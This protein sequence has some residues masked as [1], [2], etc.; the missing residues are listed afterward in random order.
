MFKKILALTL[1]A[2]ML[3]TAAM[4]EGWTAPAA[5]DPMSLEGDIGLYLNDTFFYIGNDMAE[6]KAVLGE[7]D[8]V[9]A[10]PSCAFKG[11]DKEY[12]YPDM[13]VMTM[14]LGELD[15]WTE[16]YIEGGDYITSRGIGIGATED[17]VLAAYGD[18]YYMEGDTMF[19]SLSG[20]PEDLASPYISFTLEGGA[21]VCIDIAYPTNTL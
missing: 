8:D 1:C 4:A 20:D 2:L 11:E 3:M 18:G 6:L 7:A 16:A 10:T 17:E 15:V 9:I 13:S 12:V 5:G 21:V 14:P 19:Y